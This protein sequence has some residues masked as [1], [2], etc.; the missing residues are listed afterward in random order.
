MGLEI[1][2]PSDD[3]DDDYDG[4]DDEMGGSGGWKLN[5]PTKLAKQTLFTLD[6]FE[7]HIEGPILVMK[8]LSVMLLCGL[9][10]MWMNIKDQIKS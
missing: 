3:D 1:R 7:N 10:I 5:Q 9:W 2:G 4:D 6:H 8:Y